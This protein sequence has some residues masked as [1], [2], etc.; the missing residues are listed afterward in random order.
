VVSGVV[1]MDGTLTVLQLLL[2]AWIIAGLLLGSLGG[3]EFVR[4]ASK[5][6]EKKTTA[7]RV[8]WLVLYPIILLRAFVLAIWHTLT[9]R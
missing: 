6:E 4:R 9:P 2:A 3:F 8:A 7:Y 1:T 5:G